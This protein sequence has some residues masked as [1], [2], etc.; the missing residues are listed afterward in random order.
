M[1]HHPVPKK[2]LRRPLAPEIAPFSQLPSIL[3][4]VY[5]ARD[6]TKP[7]ELDRTLARLPSPRLLSG[8]DDMVEQLACALRDKLHILVVA[9]FDADGAT[10]C[11][12]ALLGLQALGA[13]QVSY[14]VPNRFEF[15]YGLTPE[16]VDV[17]VA[18]Q[19]DILLTVDNGISSL[20]GVRTAKSQGLRVLITDHHLPGAELPEADAIVNPNMPGD[21][22][23][24]KSLAGVG[25]M[26]YVLMAL[27]A[28][29]RD[30]GW[31]ALSG[32]SEPN[33]GQL[34]DLVALGTVADVVNLDHVNRILVHQGLRRI[35]SGGARPGINALLEVAGRKPEAISAAD[36]G[37]AAA[38][39]LNAAGRLEDMGLGIECL[40]SGYPDKARELAVR[41]DTLN[42]ERR[43]IE[44]QMKRD[45]FALLDNQ[46]LACSPEALSGIC[47]F[48]PSWHQGVI[49]I[50]AARLKDRL[51]RPVIAFAPAGEGSIKGSAR[52]IPGVHIRDVLSD[53]AARHPALLSRFGGHAMAAGLSLRKTDYEDFAAVFDEEVGRH[54]QGLD[55]A[56]ALHS[57]GELGNEELRLEAAELLQNAGPWGQGFP[58]PLFDGEFDV[59]QARVIGEKHLKLVLQT[60]DRQRSIDG[61]A[62]FVEHPENW[63]GCR[64]LKAAYRLDVN[65]FRDQRSVQLRIEYMESCGA[66]A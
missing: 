63:L 37:F 36:L 25:V 35:R 64:R 32:I 11:A 1:L 42:K 12:V 60:P 6:L 41:L 10:S 19:P 13:T 53:I 51:N 29:L 33:L 46:Q 9:D 28:R 3:Q 55:L 66:D 4:R 18:R 31:F 15:G 30:D 34:L 57:D 40:L 44:D 7:E 27:R 14:L 17:A 59:V 52:S 43:E 58:E 5:R 54:L 16:I 39:R 21:S 22:F 26:F 62:F 20:E 65:E 45:A 23:P 49:G 50:L 61:I 38:P 56:H 8:M 48:D 24:S 47:L 2:I